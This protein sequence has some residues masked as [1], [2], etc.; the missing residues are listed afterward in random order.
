VV[1][2]G[3]TYNY[4]IRSLDNNISACV[5]CGGGTDVKLSNK[6]SAHILCTKSNH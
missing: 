4:T 1:V 3:G 5:V 6:K 2:V